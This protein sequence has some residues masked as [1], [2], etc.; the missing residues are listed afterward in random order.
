MGSLPLS[1]LCSWGKWT[2]GRLNKFPLGLAESAGMGCE[3]QLISTEENFCCPIK[4][5]APSPTLPRKPWEA[6]LICW[7]VYFLT[8]LLW[9]SSSAPFSSTY[10]RHSYRSFPFVSTRSI[11]RRWGMRSSSPLGETSRTS[12]RTSWRVTFA[13]VRCFFNRKICYWT[14]YP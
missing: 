12:W 10:H 3:L 8:W 1:P 7:G 4:L 11:T 13:W 9:L 14:H 2:P 5:S 6:F